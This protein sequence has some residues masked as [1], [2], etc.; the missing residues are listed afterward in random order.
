VRLIPA[1]AVLALL[2]G[3]ASNEYSK[4]PE[5][6]GDWVPANPPSLMAENEP[7]PPPARVPLQRRQPV[8]MNTV[9]AR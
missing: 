8:R 6:Q 9:A 1:L 3:C 2:G 4:V 7:S 5:P